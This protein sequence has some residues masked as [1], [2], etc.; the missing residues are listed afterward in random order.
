MTCL[1]NVRYAHQPKANTP[2]LSLRFLPT[3]EFLGYK[4]HSTLCSINMPTFTNLVLHIAVI[5]STQTR[6]SITACVLVH[7]CSL[8]NEAYTLDGWDIVFSWIASNL[9]RKP[10]G[11]SLSVEQ[12]LH[13]CNYHRFLRF[14]PEIMYLFTSKWENNRCDGF[15]SISVLPCWMSH[16]FPWQI[17]SITTINLCLV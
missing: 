11:A 14:V 6:L 13:C 17:Q 7:S 5:S 15:Q 8:L 9:A 12:F 1:F 3:R 4:I 16:I 2:D 10:W